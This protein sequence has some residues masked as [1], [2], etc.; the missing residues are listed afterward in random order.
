[1]PNFKGIV[2]F[3]PPLATIFSSDPF[4]PVM[5]YS[6]SLSFSKT[7]LTFA[8]PYVNLVR[9]SESALYDLLA[10]KENLFLSLN[11]RLEYQVYASSFPSTLFTIPCFFGK[12]VSFNEQ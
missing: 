1:M 4:K 7:A 8:V 2:T 10:K 3:S 5:T 9:I 11:I 12:I 6:P